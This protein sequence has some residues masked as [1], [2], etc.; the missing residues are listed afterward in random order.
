MNSSIAL[1]GVERV[2]VGKSW[3]VSNDMKCQEFTFI[4]LDGGH[5]TVAAYFPQLK[6]EES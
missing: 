4:G 1:H 2:I 6:K 3:F 5:M